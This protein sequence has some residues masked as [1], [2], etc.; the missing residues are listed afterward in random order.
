MAEDRKTGVFWGKTALSFVE[1]VS[2][3]PG[4]IFSVPLG[5][6]TAETVSFVQNAFRQQKLPASAVN[7]SLPAKDIIFRSFVIPW[8]QP[9][10][11]RGVVDFEASKYVPF[12]LGD[13][14]YS[15]YPMTIVEGTV[16][17][18]RVI[19]VAIKKT[20]LEGYTKIL[21]GASL[22]VNIS[23]PG[24]LSLIRALVSKNLLPK[25]ETIALIER[26][27]ESGNI[28][29]VDR[30][31]SQFVR[32]FQLRIPGSEQAPVDPQVSM[33]RMI[34]EVRISL[35]YFT[36]Q[37]ERF[38]IKRVMFVP[39]F[40]D[41]DATRR[42]E[43]DL[44]MPVASISTDSILTAP[45]N[46]EARPKG[47]PPA[48]G[49]DFLKACGAAL[50]QAVSLPADLNFSEGKQKTVKPAPQKTAATPVQYK[51]ILL[52]A[53]VCLPVIALPFF[54]SGSSVKQKENQKAVLSARLKSFKDVSAQKMRQDNE[55][56][57]ARLDYFKGLPVSS[58]VS[59]LLALVPSLLPDGAWVDQID[60]V[61]PDIVSPGKKAAT[62]APNKAGRPSGD[63]PAVDIKGYV[64]SSDPGEQFKLVNDLL[65][66]FKGNKV[67]SELFQNINFE[68]IQT[69]D[70]GKYPATF[71]SLKCR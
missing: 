48:N 22:R 68:T 61:Y 19:F 12:A 65:A 56:I 39:P 37:E 9:N 36:R 43:E 16:R 45:P 10:E 32:E 21:E 50:H 70:F 17:R 2:G 25:D 71:F 15:F 34:N 13:L 42:L 3:K 44:R 60:V 51:A 33:T 67:F 63:K 57:T 47:G 69:K 6:E 7:L 46:G 29:V 66:N 40:A 52:T 53:L 26:T 41:P 27:E 5:K 49:V 59:S 58:E 64:Y 23:E 38:K 14:S 28:I 18:V 11:I 30:C 54:L 8:M 4:R 20:V 1:V 35:N 24:T 62:A 31:L 55:K